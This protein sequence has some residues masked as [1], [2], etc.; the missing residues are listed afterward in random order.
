MLLIYRTLINFFF[1]LIILIIF[2]RRFLN[3]ENKYR[4]KEKLFSSHFDIKKKSKKRLIWFHAA[5]IG[6]IK[7]II[8]VVKK[9]NKGEKFDFLITTT[10]LSSANLI[11]RDLLIE[12]NV[13]HRF[14]PIDKYSLVSRFLDG[15]SPHLIIFVDSEIWPNFILEIKKRKIPLVLLNGRITKKTFLRWVR[16]SKF[17]KKIFQSF[18]LC[19]PS[20]EES[21]KY[22]KSFDVKN[23]KFFGNIKFAAPQKIQK[24]SKKTHDLINKRLFW[25]A[26]SVHAGEDI[27]CLNVHL[28]LRK[29]HNNVST[30]IIPR[31]IDNVREIRLNCE[32]FNLSYQ[33]L[34]NGE[35]IEENKEILIINSYGVMSQF[36]AMSNSVFIGK[37]MLKKLSQVG[38]QNPI[39]AAKLGCKIYHGPHVYN[40]NEIYNLLE[41]LK[42][43]EKIFNEDQLSNKIS[44]D[45][46][47]IGQN[48]ND[49][50]DVINNLG[51]KIL[52]QTCDELEKIIL[53]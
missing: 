37:S 23:I 1:P 32:K 25:C 50:I 48:R 35:N 31:H 47:K 30:I 21:K 24:L 10:T 9:L 33:I 39:E 46:N 45:F 7:S 11:E 34:S 22:L 12:K 27:F 42:I 53:K 4:Y 6:E 8:P 44:F 40:F 3:K 49:K 41:E 5:S 36:L 19:I 15:W 13:I 17:A 18:Y 51:E 2:I 29:T 20:N 52:L 16:L 43:S 38:G 28:K 26:V 14:F